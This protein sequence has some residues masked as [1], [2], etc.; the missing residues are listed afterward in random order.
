MKRILFLMLLAMVAATAAPY[1]NE[2]TPGA[3]KGPA[4]APSGI[5]PAPKIDE[6]VLVTLSGN[7]RPEAKAANDRGA[8]PDSFRLEHMML[9]LRRT[10]QQEQAVEQ[11]IDQLYDRNS[12]NFR[13]WL[14]AKE[15]GLKYGLPTGKLDL[16]T[17]WLKAQGFVVDVVYP[18]HMVIDFSGNAGL[19][20][21]A[22]HTELHYLE[23]NGERHFANMSDP[24][25][26]ST[27]APMVAGIVA[28]HDFKAYPQSARARRGV[29]PDFTTTGGDYAVAPADL[30]TIYNF[31]QLFADG[32]TGVGQTVVVVEDS[33][34]SNPGDFDTFRSVLGLSG[35]SDGSFTTINP[36]SG[37]TNNC[38][39]AGVTGAEG[40]AVLDVEMVTSAAPSA[41]VVLASCMDTTGNPYGFFTAAQNLI[42]SAT[43]PGII[44]MSY[45]LPETD[46][47]SGANAAINS[48]YQQGA[49]EGVSIFVSSGDQSAA[50]DRF[51]AGSAAAHGIRINGFGS[52]PYNVSV[53]ATDFSDS[54]SQTNST[55]WSATNG[56]TYGSAMSYIP[57]IPMSSSCGNVL[58]ADA[59]GY[60]GITYGIDGFCN[61]SF[62]ANN[63]LV[64]TWGTSGGPSG[65]ATGAPTVGDSNGNVVS[66]TCAGY[67]KPSWQSGFI[68][69][70][71][72]GRRDIPD[73]S[74]FGAVPVSL[75]PVWEHAYVVCD[76]GGGGCTGSD[77]NNW[78]LVGGTSAATPVMAGLQALLMQTSGVYWGNLDPYYYFLASQ[79]YGASG[80]SDCDTNLGNEVG[81]D[82]IFYDET[83]VPLI[84]GGSGTG[85]DM[86]V[87]CT[88]T[89]TTNNC[90]LPSGTYGVL[91]TS[92]SSYQPAYATTT[93]WDFA[94]G[95]GSP[96]AYNLVAALSPPNPSLSPSSLAFAV[97]AIGTTSA[98][99]SANLSNADLGALNLTSIA[100][101]GGNNTDFGLS[102]SCPGT[103]AYGESCQLNVTFK[104]TGPG[105][106]HAS[107]SISD[108][109]GNTPQTVFLAG[110]GTAASLLPAS[111]TFANQAQGT[112]SAA[113]TV[114]LKN[115]GSKTMHI[116]QIAIEG[117]NPGD[118]SK[119]TTCGA[120]LAASV[121]C[122]VSVTFKPT[123]TGS[124]SAS[125]L[126]STTGGGTPAVAV[127]G[128]GT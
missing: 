60:D 89:T 5:V 49:T 121:S 48:A 111:L 73:I 71:N 96:N 93:G 109:A 3:H 95:I 52:T 79:E 92:T 45:G 40:E 44:S 94:T 75:N 112:S 56:S 81:S 6:S 72:D 88:T 41:A 122:T 117:A 16:I 59:A 9:Q 78:A 29:H 66:G 68:G 103:L 46:I 64:G 115:V 17:G 53:G 100:L 14:S 84:Y 74:L 42:N 69:I 97:Q 87:P 21:R 114:T 55:Y 120:T 124:R 19:V 85:S 36:P 99:K 20:R 57:E 32:V 2:G 35:Y 98:A 101:T 126:F 110:V 118:F 65:C 104:P 62:A 39:D 12:P 91:S 67:A 10:P 1:Q 38:S 23:A 15:F 63:N 61:S 82:C 106:R 18:N 4:G 7:T 108:N 47:G 70:H 107:I 83:P 43:P 90:Y 37:G 13:H 119:T 128:T 30:A 102:Q 22:F 51:A 27:L 105:P 26:P 80:S 33:D 11:F 113:K 54:Y 125:V 76:T 24:K 58:V 77:P 31:N 50:G 86:D 123:A 28:L 25:I 34:V 8:V 116:W 127:T